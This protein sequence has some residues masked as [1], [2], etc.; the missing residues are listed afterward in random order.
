MF[1]KGSFIMIHMM[2]LLFLAACGN[3]AEEE[4]DQLFDA[5]MEVHS[6][7]AMIELLD[8]V[9]EEQP[10]ED[11]LDAAINENANSIQALQQL[12]LSTK[13]AV[14]NRNEYISGIED[15]QKITEILDA[16]KNDLTDEIY[17]EIGILLESANEKQMGPLRE[18]V[19]QS[20]IEPPTN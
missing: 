18:K 5:V 10:Y 14:D 17:T 1:K 9:A 3:K 19:K 2:L 13:K 15:F 20:D 16:N 4:I 8:A 6:K 11:M 7:P 12:E